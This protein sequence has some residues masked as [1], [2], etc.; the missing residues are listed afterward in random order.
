MRITR[1]PASHIAQG[2][3]RKKNGACRL[4]KDYLSCHEPRERCN[5]LLRGSND[6]YPSRDRAAHWRG[7]DAPVWPA[8]G[9]PPRDHLFCASALRTF[10]TQRF[11]KLSATSAARTGYL[12][13]P[14]YLISHANR[15]VSMGIRSRA[16][17][18]IHRGRKQLA[19]APTLKQRA[20]Q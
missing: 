2:V 11:V 9:A 13:D 6:E 15:I 17:F 14:R 12:T 20:S 1:R 5:R 7:E 8:S 3:A 10:I 19:A 4:A 18:V 16:E